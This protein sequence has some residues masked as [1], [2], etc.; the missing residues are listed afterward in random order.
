M[1]RAPQQTMPAADAQRPREKQS[2]PREGEV[3]NPAAKVF[4]LNEKGSTCPRGLV[5]LGVLA[6]PLIV[7]EG[8]VRS[9]TG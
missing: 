5:V 1:R 4:E 7:L 6:V 2:R 9:R 3:L 8:S